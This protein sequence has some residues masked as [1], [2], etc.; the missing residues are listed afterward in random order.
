[1]RGK[2]YEVVSDNGKVYV[3]FK[4]S[5]L[6]KRFIDDVDN[7]ARVKLI[8]GCVVETLDLIEF[9]IDLKKALGRFK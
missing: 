3:T 4:N 1:M 9:E 6:L 5:Y 2:N 8:N 7:V